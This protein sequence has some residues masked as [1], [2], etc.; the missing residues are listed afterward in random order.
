MMLTLSNAAERLMK[1]GVH[2]MLIYR[3]FLTY[4][5]QSSKSVQQDTSETSVIFV[6]TIK[7]RRQDASSEPRDLLRTT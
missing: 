4:S 2:I 6:F 3:D 1:K 5:K 7:R